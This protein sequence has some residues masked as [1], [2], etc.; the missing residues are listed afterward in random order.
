MV[1]IKPS[2]GL[3]P[4][5]EGPSRFYPVGEGRVVLKK[6]SGIVRFEINKCSSS[7]ELR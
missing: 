2:D 5:C 4:D 1:G 6:L 3:E 7:E